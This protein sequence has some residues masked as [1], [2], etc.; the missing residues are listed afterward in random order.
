MWVVL[1][2]YDWYSKLYVRIKWRGSFSRGFYVRSGVRQGSSLSPT[3]FNVSINRFIV[4]LKEDDIGCKLGGN[5]VGVIMYAD[6]LLLL[7]LSVTGLQ[8]M[9]DRCYSICENSYLEFNTNKCSCAI[10]GPAAKYNIDN[11]KL[12]NS[13][14]NWTT[15]IKYLGI[16]FQVGKNMIIDTSTIKRK[17]FSSVNCIIGKTKCINERIRLALMESHCLS[18]LLYSCAALGY[19]NQQISDLNACWNSV[20]R[21]IFGFNKWESVRD[22]IAGLGRMDFISIQA[23]MC[24][25]LPKEG[26]RS[27]NLVF[28]SLVKRFMFTQN[29]KQLC[30]NVNVRSDCMYLVNVSFYELQK[31]VYNNFC[32]RPSRRN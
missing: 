11:M 5:F 24:L 29:F 10:I 8:H 9:L 25:K 22:C 18:V 15:V 20:Y 3:L 6:D 12:G 13:R 26:F 23:H 2:L 32:N 7:S 14:L 19:N 17:F 30:N 1:I 16:N 27:N 4:E 31:L 21:R 28:C